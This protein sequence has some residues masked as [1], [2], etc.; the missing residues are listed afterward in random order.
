MSLEFVHFVVTLGVA[1]VF[2]RLFCV[3]Y[4]INHFYPDGH[5]L[6]FHFILLVLKFNLLDIS[7]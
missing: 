2:S 7:D 1:K 6:I 5:H 4:C 3:T